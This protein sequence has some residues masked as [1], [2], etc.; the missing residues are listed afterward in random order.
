MR[1]ISGCR[2]SPLIHTA[3]TLS[4]PSRLSHLSCYLAFLSRSSSPPLFPVLIPLVSIASMR[5]HPDAQTY[6]AFDSLLLLP[7]CS[8][9]L[10]SASPLAPASPCEVPHSPGCGRGGLRAVD[11]M[12][13]AAPM[14]GFGSI[15][16]HSW[17]RR[18]GFM[19]LIQ[20]TRAK[21][22]EACWLP[23]LIQKAAGRGSDVAV[24]LEVCK[25]AAI[26]TTTVSGGDSD[27]TAASE[28]CK[29]A[30][31]MHNAQGGG[32][33]R[34]S[35]IGGGNGGQ[36]LLASYSDSGVNIWR[37]WRRYVWID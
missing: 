11:S 12:P 22:E 5:Q 23:V 32:S 25:K 10:H 9:L 4:P 34:G 27:A 28:V 24:V 33:A 16:R 1:A 29:V 3:E 18:N 15:S 26:A 35:D 14:E 30:D 21:A 7:T 20:E 31:V 6:Q 19:V 2:L 36:G 37:L 13:E 8:S 17:Q